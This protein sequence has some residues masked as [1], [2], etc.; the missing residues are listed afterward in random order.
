[1]MGTM[2]VMSGCCMYASRNWVLANTIASC[3]DAS[4]VKEGREGEETREGGAEEYSGD[5][6]AAANN[7]DGF[8][9]RF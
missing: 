6:D 7:S 4:D 8:R 2:D 9:L 1:M 5:E 3:R